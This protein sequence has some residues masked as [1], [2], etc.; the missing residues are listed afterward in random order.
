MFIRR[1]L[2][3][4]YQIVTNT[5][6]DEFGEFLVFIGGVF[7]QADAEDCRPANRPVSGHVSISVHNYSDFY[8]LLFIYD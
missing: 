8:Y 5:L 6:K 3:F 4:W 7:L 1:L 2:L